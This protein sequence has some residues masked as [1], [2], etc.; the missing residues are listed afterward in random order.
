LSSSYSPLWEFQKFLK[1]DYMDRGGTA[2][3]EMRELSFNL[4][5]QLRAL[6]ENE[7]ESFVKCVLDVDALPQ[8][9]KNLF[10]NENVTNMSSISAFELS[11]LDVSVFPQLPE[12]SEA[13]EE[14]IIGHLL[15]QYLDPTI[16]TIQAPH[17]RT[18]DDLLTQPLISTPI[19]PKKIVAV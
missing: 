4:Y 15:E 5:P 11:S 13:A 19:D 7:N 8:Y 2:T 9:Y 3:A 17:D 14:R 10:E 12:L 1:K 18:I 16:E 6:L